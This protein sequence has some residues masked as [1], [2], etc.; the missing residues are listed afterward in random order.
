MLG[1]VGKVRVTLLGGFAVAVDDLPV[2][3]GAWRLRKARELVK[4]LSLAPGHRLHR[5]QAMDVLWR[6]REP[7]AAANNLHQAV[8]VARRALDAEAIEVREEVLQL[9]ADVDVDRLELAAA[10]ARRV[11]HS[12][13]VSRCAVVFIAASCCRRIVTTIGRKGDGRSS[14]SWPLSSTDELAALGDVDR[15]PALPLDASSFVGRDHELAE[16]KALLRGSRLVTLAGVGGVGKTRLALEL[17]R[18]AARSS[19][20]R[21]GSRR[22]GAR[23][24]SPSSCRMRLRRRSTFVRCPDRASTM[25]SSSFSR[26][27]R[28][29]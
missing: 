24:R 1:L 4:L 18:G 19:S 16:L 15:S 6:D 2:P 7:A 13:R 8:F 23:L 27:V 5:E 10:D 3:E 11:R 22:A 20:G 14:P 26:R 25:Q 29:C 9:R 28:F 12:R 17:A 21:R